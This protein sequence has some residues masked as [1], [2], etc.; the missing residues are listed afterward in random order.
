MNWIQSKIYAIVRNAHK[1]AMRYPHVYTAY[2]ILVYILFGIP[3]IAFT[4][5]GA[6]LMWE[7]K[8]IFVAEKIHRYL[9]Q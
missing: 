9:L 7:I 3:A 2:R 4:L 5:A 6:L 1:I 8:L